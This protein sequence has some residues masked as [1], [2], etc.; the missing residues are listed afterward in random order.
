M[1]PIAAARL[2]LAAVVLAFGG[3]RLAC[4]A[5]HSRPILADLTVAQQAQVDHLNELTL[6]RTTPLKQD[7]SRTRWE[8]IALLQ[9]PDPDK[10]SVEAKLREISRLEDAIQREFVQHVLRVKQVLTPAQQERLFRT[11]GERLSPP[12]PGAWPHGGPFW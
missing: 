4:H 2:F 9:Q 1:K 5:I 7:L 10:A 6:Q 3:A 11:M 8:L 12:S